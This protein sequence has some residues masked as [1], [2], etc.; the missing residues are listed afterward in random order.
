MES[1]YSTEEERIGDEMCLYQQP[2]GLS[3][4]VFSEGPI[5]GPSYY[6][7][8]ADP[9]LHSEQHHPGWN[10]ELGGFTNSL[11]LGF[12]FFLEVCKNLQI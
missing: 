2:K 1:S 5:R 9:L 12:L 11:W 6:S 4:V 7:K 8:M 10:T 3:T